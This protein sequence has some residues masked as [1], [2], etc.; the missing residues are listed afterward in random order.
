MKG[1]VAKTTLAVNLADVLNRSHG[2]KVAL[3][4]VDP[5]FNATQCLMEPRKYTEHLRSALS[6]VLDVFETP[7]VISASTVAGKITPKEKSLKDIKLV[8]IRA[9]FHLLPGNLELYRVEMKSSEGREFRLKNFINDVLK[10]EGFDIVIIDTPPTPSVWM[11]SALIAS[12]AYLIPVRPDPISMTGIDLLKGIVDYR[13]QNFG[14]KIDCLGVV[15]TVVERIDSVIYTESRKQLLKDPIWSNKVFKNYLPKRQEVP[16]EQLN[17]GFIYDS[18]DS[19][20]R[21]SLVAI[22]N[23][24]LKGLGL[25]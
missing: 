6:T 2:K 15:F 16:R 10:D 9:N 21:R 23:E 22:S 20:L 14:L 12:N 5:Q 13:K 1:G 25:K 4:D 24:L 17:Q 3:I 11:T 18:V 7:P 19:D 8:E